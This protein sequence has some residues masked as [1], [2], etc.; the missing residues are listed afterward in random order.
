MP[1]VYRDRAHA[2]ELLAARLAH[3]A[4]ADVTVLALPRG[5]VPVA[6]P[7]AQALGAPL[8]ILA[9]RKLGVPGHEELAM[10]A[11]ASGGVRVLN[12][13]VVLH[14]RIDSASIEAVTRAEL[15]RLTDQERFRG[16]RPAAALEGR[17]VILVDDGLATGSTME[18]AIA[19]C[20]NAAVA[21][22]VVAVPVGAPQTVAYLAGLADEVICP[23]TPAVFRAVGL[24]Y[25][26]FSPVHNDEV[27][28]LLN[29][30]RPDGI[31]I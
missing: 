17:T 10:G 12:N 20:R 22:I 23:L 30:S 27:R 24:V 5:G 6:Y 25:G 21:G 16:N 3:Y 31:G 26:D 9:V 4:G 11:V 28:A 2:G 8:D 13:D 14:L 7:V 1:W 18:A 19:A 15:A 29:R